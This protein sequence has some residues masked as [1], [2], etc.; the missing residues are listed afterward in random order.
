MSQETVFLAS[1]EAA[2]NDDG[3]RLVYA[4]WLEEQG[5]LRAE[6]LRLEVE[7]RQSWSYHH[8]QRKLRKRMRKLR[9]RLDIQWL[10]QVRRCTTP[11]PPIDV[12]QVVPFLKGRGKYTWR[13][14]PRT[15]EAPVDAS[16]IGGTFIW[17]MSEPQP[18]C[19]EHHCPLV[20]AIQLRKQD[21]SDDVAFKEHADLL[22][23]LWCPRE[24]RG[25]MH[26]RAYWRNRGAITKADEVKPPAKTTYSLTPDACVL[27]PEQIL[28]FP[29]RHDLPAEEYEQLAT[30]NQLK[31][32]VDLLGQMAIARVSDYLKADYREPI[33]PYDD[34]LSTAPGTK[35]GGYP[36]WES[37]PYFPP[38]GTCSG[39]MTF[40]LSCAVRESGDWPRWLPIEERDTYYPNSK[41]LR[42][43]VRAANW[44]F[45][46]SEQLLVFVCQACDDWPVHASYPW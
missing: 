27:K 28:E 4:D 46:Y 24:H 29:H 30:N 38:C 13:L 6:Y 37:S 22:Q 40:L 44:S 19:P 33:R 32:A 11:P 14:H 34:Y 17:P 43:V 20:P 1:L 9:P 41:T 21:L 16:K 39:P 26:A 23:I 10:A 31:T 36:E 25:P 45:G 42:H 2:P 15:G 3:I 8:Q 18:T 12:E 5:D 7:I 35:Y